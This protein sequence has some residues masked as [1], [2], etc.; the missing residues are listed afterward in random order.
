MQGSQGHPFN[1]FASVSTMEGLNTPI[2]QSSA[3]WLQVSL[4]NQQQPQ[5]QQTLQ[6][7]SPQ[8]TTSIQQQAASPVMQH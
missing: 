7:S 1:R 2:E 8:Q 5:P 4:H 6:Q 3:Q